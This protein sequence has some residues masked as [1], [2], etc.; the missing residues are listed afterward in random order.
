M[1]TGDKMKLTKSKLKQLIKEELN[2][3]NG[4]NQLTSEQQKV[5]SL[6][7]DLVTAVYAMEK[8]NPTMSDDYIQLFRALNAVGV[9]TTAVAMMA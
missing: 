1:A 3:Y 9:N 2:E 7:E 4:E 6:I 5:I 8:S